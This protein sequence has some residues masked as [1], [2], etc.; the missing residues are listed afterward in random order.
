LVG[1]NANAL[2]TQS[3]SIAFLFNPEGNSNKKQSILL[4][5]RNLPHKPAAAAAAAAGVTNVSMVI[6][7]SS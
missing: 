1:R 4:R 3:S 7:A 2:L 6:L 5:F